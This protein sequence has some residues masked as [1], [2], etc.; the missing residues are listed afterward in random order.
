MLR[1]LTERLFASRHASGSIKD[2]LYRMHPEAWLESALRR[3]IGP[4][5]DG[6]SSLA[7]FDPEHVYAQVPAFQ[8]ETVACSTS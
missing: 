3:N 2:P 6:Q 4:L 5:T 1:S 7:E 8:P